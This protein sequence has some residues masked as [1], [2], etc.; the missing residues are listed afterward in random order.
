MFLKQFLGNLLP[1]PYTALQEV[2]TNY[3]IKRVNEFVRRQ[4]GNVVQQGPFAGML[5]VNEAACSTLTPKLIGSY[6]AELHPA[7]A[8]VFATEYSTIIDVGCAEGYYA[9]GLAIRLPRARV[10]A[11]DTDERARVLC[12]QMAKLNSVAERVFVE[13]V[14]SHARLDELIDERTLVVCD[15]EGC[16][17]EL[18]RPEVVPSLNQADLLV[19]LHDFIDPRIKSTLISR[20]EQTHQIA[21]IQTAD[22]VA[23]DYTAIKELNARSQLFAL[24]ELRGADMEWAFMR[25]R[26]AASG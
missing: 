14:C 2:W 9:V 7:L 18:L 1:G 17:F 15:C 8:Q 22:R 12:E 5:Y 23:A 24:A 3:H 20:F 16:E 10:Y 13:G 21:I 6:E 25:S 11:F 19:E 26:G 4:H